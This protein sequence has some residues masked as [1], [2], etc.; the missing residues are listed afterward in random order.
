MKKMLALMVCL[1]LLGIAWSAA[2]YA[3]VITFEDLYPNSENKILG[4]FPAGYEGLTWTYGHSYWVS[5]YYGNGYELGTVGSVSMFTESTCSFSSATTFDFT[6]AYITAV[7][8]ASES[9]TVRGWLSND[10]IYTRIITTYKITDLDNPHPYWFDFDFTGI[11]MVTFSVGGQQIV[12]DN[13][14]LTDNMNAVPL[15]GALVL[16]GSGLLPLL[17]WRRWRK[18]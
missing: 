3:R 11:D 13:I 5:I 12:V 10:E 16:F 1:S 4:D 7:L 9:V 2:A 14:T 18:G 15:P 6:G 8:D 17:G